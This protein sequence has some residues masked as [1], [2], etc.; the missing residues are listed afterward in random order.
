MLSQAEMYTTANWEQTVYSYH[1]SGHYPSFCLLFKIRRFGDWIL[2]RLQAS[3]TQLVPIHRSSLCPG[4]KRQVKVK[5]ML[6]LTVL[7]SSSLWNLCPDIIFCVK[8]AVLSLWGALYDERSGLSP[9]SHCHQCFVHC[10]VKGNINKVYKANNSNH[11][12][13]LT[14]PH[15]ESP[16]TWGLT[17]MYMRCFM[18]NI[19]KN[20]ILPE[21]EP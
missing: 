17:S 1:N 9:V 21:W 15:L 18:D 11:Q 13:E 8:V 16:P 20:K 4:H 7:V 2:P 12:R 3:P 6:R 14:F 19:V 10:Q 5:A